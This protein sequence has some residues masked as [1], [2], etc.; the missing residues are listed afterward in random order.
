MAVL[1]SNRSKVRQ[2][3]FSGG[4]NSGDNPSNI[5]EAQAELLENC[6][7]TERGRCEQRKGLQRVG[8]NPDSLVSIWTFDDS[9]SA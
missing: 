6:I 5:G 8:D 4:Q 2:A 3:D 1:T 9:S 7:I